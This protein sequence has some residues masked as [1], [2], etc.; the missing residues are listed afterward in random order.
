MSTWEDL[1]V[2]NDRLLCQVYD[3]GQENAR[4]EALLVAI[5]SLSGTGH[6]VGHKG[7]AGGRLAL[8]RGIRRIAALGIASELDSVVQHD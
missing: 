8:L 7:I 5:H 6:S 4:R 1:K 3:L 2:E